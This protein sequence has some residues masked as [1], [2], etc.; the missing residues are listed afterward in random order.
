[1][2]TVYKG[3][4]TGYIG[5][6]NDCKDM[7]LDYELVVKEVKEKHNVWQFARLQ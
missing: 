6:N 4:A 7:I 1:M 2:G 5:Y 3:D